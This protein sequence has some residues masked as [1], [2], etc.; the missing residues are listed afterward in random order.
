MIKQPMLSEKPYPSSFKEEAA[1][2]LNCAIDGGNAKTLCKQCHN[3]WVNVRVVS[4]A[5]GC[6]G[7][8]NALC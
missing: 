2:H 3:L 7:R 5:V 4:L 8:R 1:Y 6:S